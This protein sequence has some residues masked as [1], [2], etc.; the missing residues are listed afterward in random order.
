MKCMSDRLVQVLSVAILSGAAAVHCADTAG[1]SELSSYNRKSGHE[2]LKQVRRDIESLHFDPQFKG[3]DLGPVFDRAKAQIDAARTNGEV[4]FAI[5]AAVRS[6][7]DSHSA[8]LLPRRGYDHSYGWR[9]MAAGEA[10]IVFDVEKGS[11][12]ERK[13]LRRGDQLLA[14][15]REG[16]GPETLHA[17]RYLLEIEPRSRLVLTVAAPGSPPREVVVETKVTPRQRNYDVWRDFNELLRRFDDNE[18]EGRS[19]FRTYEGVLVWRFREFRT[20]EDLEEGLRRAASHDALILDLRG[21]PG[22]Y[23]DRMLELIAVLIGE[24]THVATRITR[25]GAL[26]LIAELKGR[27]PYKGRLFVLVDKGSSSA[28]EVL[29]AIVQ[30]RGRGLLL[31]DRT[32]GKVQQGKVSVHHVGL[33]KMVFYGTSIANA[34]LVLDDGRRIEGIGVTP[35]FLMAPTPADVAEY[36]DPVLAMALRQAGVTVDPAAIGRDYWESVASKD[37]W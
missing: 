33:Q 8:F 35:D 22:G 26:P 20:D 32:G 23:V 12:A 21:N 6:L 25:D 2:M 19:S 30:A 34:E 13:G 24:K 36:R 9:A 15:D 29:A 28:S 7:G 14:I 11:D 17:W 27:R 37:L 16:V 31:G 1:P 5:A 10:C 18:M 4:F 3:V